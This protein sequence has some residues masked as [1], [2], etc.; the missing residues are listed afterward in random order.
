MTWIEGTGGTDCFRGA[1]GEGWQTSIARE[2]TPGGQQFRAL[3]GHCDR[4]CNSRGRNIVVVL[5]VRSKDYLHSED[6]RPRLHQATSS[7]LTVTGTIVKAALTVINLRFA[8]GRAF[9]RVASCGHFGFQTMH[10]ARL[11]D[12]AVLPGTLQ[13]NAYEDQLQPGGGGA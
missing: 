2:A 11:S 1:R 6:S 10:F 5:D 4:D 12:S 13:A 3:L 9:V 8:S 7:S